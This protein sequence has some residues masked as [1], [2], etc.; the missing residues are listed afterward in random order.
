M[1]YFK[2]KI[3]NTI[4]EV[5]AILYVVFVHLYV[6]PFIILVVLI[7]R[8]IK[9]YMDFLGNIFNKE[10]INRIKNLRQD[11]LSVLKKPD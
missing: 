7:D 11:V 10:G 2:E 9:S 8:A 4:Y 1:K 5:I 6:I 3:K